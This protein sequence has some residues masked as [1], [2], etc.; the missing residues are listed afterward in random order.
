M[1]DGNRDHLKRSE[2]VP[3]GADTSSNSSEN[4]VGRRRSPSR[5]AEW[6][7]R[8]RSAPGDAFGREMDE[9]RGFLWLPVCFGI[10][11]LIY[12][13]LPQE[14]SALGLSIIAL[15]S[16]VA[17]WLNRNKIDRFRLLMA[18]A[19]L[20]AGTTTMKLRT[21]YVA[22]PRLPF[23]QS[24][25]V[26]GWVAEKTFA[27]RGGVRVTLRVHDIERLDPL[28]TPHFIRTT[29]RSATETI[30]VGD[31]VSVTGR[32]RPPNGPVIP[33]GYDF[34]RAA[35]YDG[36]GGVGFA[37]GAARPADIGAAPLGIRM[38]VPLGRL[39]DIVGN[40][41]TTALPGDPGWIALALVIGD[42]R[43]ISTAT[44]EA[45]WASGL[46]HILAISGLHMVLIAG[47]AFWLIRALLA[48]SAELALRWP[49][50]KWAAIGA[51]GVATFYL[52]ISGAQVATQRA[53]IMLAIMFVAVLLDR[54]AI[55]LRNVALSAFIV[56]LISPESLVT[57]SFQMS[58][59]ATIALVAAYE[60]LSIWSRA[61]S[62]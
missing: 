62:N 12:F 31:A 53:Y 11:I 4:G 37:F 35:F 36:I 23:E 17:A 52:G 29:I 21:D 18:I 44:Q 58:F 10:G 49:I 61:D 59:A 14:P 39:R 19:F 20:V 32:L 2:D 25:I 54:R 50:K 3:P 55:T 22:A 30:S 7:Y 26:T 6:V 24:T 60:E 43:G 1:S 46:G 51:L 27:S 56:L 15:M 42:R 16:V 41:V 28:E 40:R 33:G 34:A 8:L 47:S 45:M 5:I 48:L 57:A 13:C 9:G 38:L